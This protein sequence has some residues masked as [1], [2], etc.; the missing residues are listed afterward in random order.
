MVWPWQSLTPVKVAAEMC[1]SRKV[2]EKIDAPSW[3]CSAS[4][5]SFWLSTGISFLQKN[6]MQS[7]RQ[8]LENLTIYT[9]APAYNQP[10][11]SNACWLF[12]I[13]VA[14]QVFAQLPG[15]APLPTQFQAHAFFDKI[16]ASVANILKEAK[17]LSPWIQKLKREN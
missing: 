2:M 8:F 9:P 1:E 17:T 7:V 6:Q 16:I 10:D 3:T 15:L 14:E 11:N 12:S 13:A 5:K 4:F